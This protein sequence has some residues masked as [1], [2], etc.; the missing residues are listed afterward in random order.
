M[1]E[2][3]SATE[4]YLAK[5]ADGLEALGPAE[6]DDVIAEVRG[7]LAE[8][9]ADAGGDEAAVLA[10]FGGPEAFAARILEE[11]GFLSSECGVPVAPRAARLAA[12]GIDVSLWL[13]GAIV[14]YILMVL[15]AASFGFRGSPNL[16]TVV[17]AWTVTIGTAAGCVWWWARQRRKAGYASVGMQVARLRRIRIG[18]ASRVVRDR[19]IPGTVRV[20]RLL[21]TAVTVVSLAVVAL[22]LYSILYTIPLQN[23]ADASRRQAAIDTALHETS[24]GLSV[25]GWTYSALSTGGDPTGMA[26]PS[27]RAAMT[28]LIER[29]KAGKIAGYAVTQVEAP[30]YPLIDGEPSRDYT[31]VELVTVEETGRSGT[32]M[33]DYRYRVE[34]AMKFDGTSGWS[35]NTLI[36]S[37]EDMPLSQ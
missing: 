3:T 34:T 26:A 16:A 19:D 6:I 25:V 23:R 14:V 15:P 11:R 29:Y 17:L 4:H 35:G 31:V 30:N 8:A 10:T 37:V 28:A 1:P 18:S 7:H 32:A 20:R 2:P 36:T 22:F 33:A 24:A 13:V 12:L 9:L 21:P 27:A 5:L